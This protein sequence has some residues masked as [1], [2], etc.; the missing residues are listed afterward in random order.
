MTQVDF[1]IL[2]NQTADSIFPFTC[3]LIEKAYKKQHEITVHLS[4]LDDANHL[5]Q[6][7]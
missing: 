3:R 6:L 1:Y 4:N 2:Q 7:L 5:D